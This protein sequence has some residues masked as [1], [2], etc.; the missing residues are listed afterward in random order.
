VIIATAAAVLVGAA[1]AYAAFNNYNGSNVAFK[2]TGS[3]TAKSPKIVNMTETLKASAPAGDR[4]APLTNIKLKIYGVRTNGNLFPTC[5]DSQIEKDKTKFE[6]ACNP[7]SRVSQGPVNSLLGSSTDPSASG[8]TACN[9]Y[10]RVF[11]G[12]KSTQAFF[13]TTTPD[14][15]GPQYN[16]ANLPTGATPPYDG[17]ISYQGKY[18]VLNVPL[19]PSVS[20]D[21]ANAGLYG[22]L[23]KEVL[24]PISETTKVGGKTRGYMES[25]ACMGH[26]RPYSITFTAKN[27][28]APGGNGQLETQTVSG[29]AAC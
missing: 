11:N 4:A 8:G 29:S 27:Y 10:L 12:G 13:F 26:K 20:T 1:A 18:W 6:K 22:S 3:G 23:I 7:K 15:P 16:C 24:N 5:T 19:P 21:V 25:V 28:S 17:H 14:A 9:P 2:P